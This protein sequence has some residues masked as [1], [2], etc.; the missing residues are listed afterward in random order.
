MGRCGE[1]WGDSTSF[2][3]RTTSSRSA[4]VAA[5]YDQIS[6]YL[7]GAISR[8]LAASSGDLG[9]VRPDLAAPAR[10]MRRLA[11]RV[12]LGRTQACVVH[13]PT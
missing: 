8:D 6:L 10:A 13:T 3:I 4:W 12:R 1:I 9:A 2:L 11:V 5:P 7:R